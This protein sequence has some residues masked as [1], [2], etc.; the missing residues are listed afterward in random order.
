MLSPDHLQA[1]DSHPI[2]GTVINADTK[3]P[4]PGV[5][6][7]TTRLSRGTATD[8]QG[9][10]AIE[11]SPHDTLLFTSIG[12][13]TRMFSKEQ[14]TELGPQLIIELNTRVYE[15]DNVE[16]TA[17]L[18]YEAFK[19]SVVDLNVPTEQRGFQLDIP[20]D[21]YIYD[22]R[23]PSTQ[24]PV[25][26]VAKGPVSALYD[27][28]SKEGREKKK[29]AALKEKSTERKIIDARYNTEV[30]KRITNLNDEGAKRFME[31]CKFDDDL[32]LEATD[33]D[34]AVAM[35]H[36]LDEFLKQDTL[37]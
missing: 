21:A 12:F 29:L 5:H 34:L 30:V 16:V 10:F 17:Q 22:P 28:L 37:R 2:Q 11:V 7:Y 18:S 8:G 19:K 13:D 27:A 1:Q 33:Y 36:C 24:Q 6:I 35:L 15:L 23:D 3:E 20:P 9:R 32:I 4:L 14:L 31:W 25:G 26:V